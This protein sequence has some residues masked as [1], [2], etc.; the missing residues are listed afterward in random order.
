MF[1]IHNPPKGLILFTGGYCDIGIG[2]IDKLI[3]YNYF[4][5]NIDNLSGEKSQDNFEKINYRTRS[6][7]TDLCYSQ[8]LWPELE[9]SYVVHLAGVFNNEKAE[10]DHIK[11][12][13]V[14]LIDTI[15]L[16]DRCVEIGATFIYLNES[17]SGILGHIHQLVLNTIEFYVQTKGLKTILIPI[18]TQSIE[19]IQT[20]ILTSIT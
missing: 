16:L 1:K 2:V 20:K 11:A 6:S 7:F 17:M 13:E 10:A 15:R 4:V 14:N 3:E 19:E 9:F 5:Y 18:E 12:F 8:Y